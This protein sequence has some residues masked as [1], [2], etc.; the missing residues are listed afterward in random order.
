MGILDGRRGLV[1]GIANERSIAYGIARA[2]S[3]QGAE[4]LLTYQNERLLK[5][6]SPIAEELGAKLLPACDLTRDDDIAALKEACGDNLDFVVH[7]VAYAKR[8]ELEGRFI[9]T[10][11]EGFAMAMDVSVYSLV[12]LVRAL[13]P[14]LAKSDDGSVVTM[15]Y[16]GSSVAIPNYNVMGVAKAALEATVRYLASELGEAGTR[17]NALSAGPIRTLSAAGVSGLRSMLQ[18]VERDAP[19]RRNVTI[20][21]VGR[22]ALFLLSELGSGVTGEIVYVDG[23]YIEEI[24]ARKTSMLISPVLARKRPHCCMKAFFIAL[25]LF[26][27]F[28]FSSHCAKPVSSK[29]PK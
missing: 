13:E 24:T 23:G 25:M 10:G 5:R 11:R 14:L 7:A 2:A 1:V 19:L 4:L 6:V 20:D 21:D 12:A 18:V 9:D 16:H 22:A 15:T 27:S 29:L 8:E 28:L 26:V 3:A 17:V